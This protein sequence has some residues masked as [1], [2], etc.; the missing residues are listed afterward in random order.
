MK[1]TGKVAFRRGFMAGFSAPYQFMY[2]S[3]FRIAHPPKNLVS[4]SW[5]KVGNAVREAIEAEREDVGKTSSSTARS[6]RWN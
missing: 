3:R 1:N 6:K 4:S 5:E 2:G